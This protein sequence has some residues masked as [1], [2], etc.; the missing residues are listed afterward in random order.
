MG[1]KCFLCDRE[2]AQVEFD[3]V[4]GYILGTIAVHAVEVTCDEN[5]IPEQGDRFDGWVTVVGAVDTRVTAVV[6]GKVH[7]ISLLKESDEGNEYCLELDE[8]VAEWQEEMPRHYRLS[9]GPIVD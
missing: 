1:M 4:T 7:S 8:G 3:R 2:P 5:C 6:K 9:C